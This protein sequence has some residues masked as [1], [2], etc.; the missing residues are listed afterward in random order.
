MQKAAAPASTPVWHYRS[1]L[2]MPAV[3]ATPAW[4]LSVI[5]SP[6]AVAGTDSQVQDM[7]G[8]SPLSAALRV[9]AGSRHRRR[10]GLGSRRAADAGRLTSPRIAEACGGGAQA[11][12]VAAVEVLPDE[13]ANSWL[14]IRGH[15]PV[16]GLNQ[17]QVSHS[18]ARKHAGPLVRLVG[19]GTLTPNGLA[20]TACSPACR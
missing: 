1:G 13:A 17:D 18:C 8:R 10:G 16:D 5:G 12:S 7:A 9:P 19:S 2:K 4:K 15:V 6:L 11:N 14:F 3:S 20:D